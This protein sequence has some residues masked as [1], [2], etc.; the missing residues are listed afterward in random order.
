VQFLNFSKTSWKNQNQRTV[1][2]QKI[3]IKE[4]SGSRY[5]KTV[6]GL[7]ILSPIF[8]GSVTKWEPSSVIYL[9]NRSENQQITNVVAYK[10]RPT[11]AFSCQKWGE[12]KSKYCQICI[13]SFDC[14]AIH[15]KWWWKIYILFL[16]Y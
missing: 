10:N 5:F 16:I 12:K 8:P 1:V 7:P 14:I 2:F 4:P 3:E 13:F 15:V 11:L 6:K 9:Y